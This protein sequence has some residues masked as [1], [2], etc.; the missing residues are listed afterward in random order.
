MA[1][2]IPLGSITVKAATNDFKY[3]SAVVNHDD[4][5]TYV[6]VSKEPIH[7]IG[8]YLN[9]DWYKIAIGWVNKS[10]NNY[11]IVNIQYNNSIG[12]WVS[13]FDNLKERSVS[14]PDS[15][16]FYQIYGVTYPYYGKCIYVEN[17]Q[18]V[19]S[20]NKMNVTLYSNYDISA[21]EKTKI[22]KFSTNFD[23]LNLPA[24]ITE[25]T[26]IDIVNESINKT[27]QTTTQANQI[28]GNLTSDYSSYQRGDI[29]SET[30]Q[31]SV[32]N[33]V[34]QLNNLNN[35]SSNT[36]ADLMAINNG[37]TYA[38]TVQDKINADEIILTQSVTPTVQTNIN[39][40]INQANN[41]YNDFTSGNK[42]QSESIEIIQQQIIN[43]NNMIT[44][45]QAS[46]SADIAAVNAAINTVQNTSNSVHNYSEIDKT[47]SDKAQQSDQE[48]IEYLNSLETTQTIQDM[49]PSQV[50]KTQSQSGN[51]QPLLSVV[52]D[53]ELIKII[54]PLTAGFL[55]ISVA[56][57][58]KFK[59]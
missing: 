31:V 28:Q 3:I 20:S 24:G 37:L 19:G 17:A 51:V 57:G 52:W 18:F 15:S 54:L 38:Q 35:S 56:L 49:S 29:S 25:N 30:L 1:G 10:I 22:K 43:L 27:T 21:T 8:D 50:M 2:L 13:T 23:E 16:K 59:L 4:G 42:T 32:N 48:E 9:V 36:L 41:A 26:I 47:V 7:V 5:T 6:Y 53:N 46:T 12:Q 45:G 40:Y 14:K 33:S 44:S 58:R 55:V 39:G 34:D 11:E